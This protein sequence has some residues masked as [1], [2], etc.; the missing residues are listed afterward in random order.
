M[1][2]GLLSYYAELTEHNHTTIY[3]LFLYVDTI[4]YSKHGKYI[5][6][7]KF[8]NRKCMKIYGQT[9]CSDSVLCNE[10]I[11][12][13]CPILSLFLYPLI[14]LLNGIYTWVVSFLFNGI[15]IDYVFY[16]WVDIFY[17]L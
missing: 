10:D 14:F 16:K 8:V 17:Y 15:Y 9:L 4:N 6:G 11:G 7:P 13:I 1:I 12:L 2:D 5:F 3:L